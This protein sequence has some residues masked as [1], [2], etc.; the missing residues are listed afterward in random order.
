MYLGRRTAIPPGSIRLRSRL[1]G[2][3]RATP[4]PPNGRIERDRTGEPSGTL[5]ESAMGLVWK[6]APGVHA[7]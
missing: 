2:I 3:T 6:P 5:R 4:D 7:G 1:A